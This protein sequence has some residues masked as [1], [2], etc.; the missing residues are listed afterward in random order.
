MRIF[1]YIVTSDS[2]FSPNPF[3]DYCTLACCKPA[4]RRTA[5]MGDFVIGI[6]PKG[7]KH[8]V[9]Y[10]MKVT[11]NPVTFGEYFTDERFLSKI[12]DYRKK[13]AVYQRGDNIYRP[14]GNGEYRQLPSRHSSGIYENS[15]SKKRDLSG[16]RV[17]VSDKFTYFGRDAIDLPGDLQCLIATRGHK[18]RFDESVKERFLAFVDTLPGGVRGL[19]LIWPKSEDGEELIIPPKGNKQHSCDSR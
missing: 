5:E 3:W 10:V 8:K 16:E 15:E 17:L 13:G 2:G 19:P 9:V 18:C 12:P 7:Q 4:I 6:S 14:H 11:E 1:S